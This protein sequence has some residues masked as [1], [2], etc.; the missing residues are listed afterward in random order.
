[1]LTPEQ[2]ENFKEKG[3]VRIPGAF[4]KTSAS[5]MED[6]VWDELKRLNGIDRQNRETW[7]IIQ[8]TKLQEIKQDPVFDPIGGPA[9]IGAIDDLLGKDRWQYPSNWGQFL[10]TF[11]TINERWNVPSDIWHADFDYDT[12]ADSLGGLLLT[13]FINRVKPRSGGT[14]F[15]EGSHRIVQQ[16]VRKQTQQF[17]TNMKRVRKALINSDPWLID[18]VTRDDKRDRVKH[19][20]ETESVVSGVAVKVAEMTGEPGDIIIG[21][22]WLLHTPAP[23]CG[24][25]PRMMRVQRV[26]CKK[27]V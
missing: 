26:R 16:F 27:P 1:M 6:Q 2:K 12:P 23:N 17:R 21:H 10:V 4:S 25:W 5:A 3:F 24:D 9:A 14:A 13:S 20:M 19:F 15:V 22:P 8:A 7:S 18:L 11:P